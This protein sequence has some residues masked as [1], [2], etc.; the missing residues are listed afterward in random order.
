M[1]L[2]HQ[3]RRQ[4]FRSVVAG[5]LS[6]PFIGRCV[7]HAQPDSAPVPEPHSDHRPWRRVTVSTYDADGNLLHRNETKR[8][9]DGPSFRYDGLKRVTTITF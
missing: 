9:A 6:W 2:C 1:E 7:V 3:S 8:R 5:M 4:F